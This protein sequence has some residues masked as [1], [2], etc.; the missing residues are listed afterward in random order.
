[1]FPI[2]PTAQAVVDASKDLQ[3]LDAIDQMLTSMSVPHNRS[4]GGLNTADIPQTLF[5][6]I[7]AKKADDVFF[8]RSGQNG[9]FF[10]VTGEESRPL[11][12]EAAFNV[13]RQFIRAEK[14]K[15][16]LGFS[17]VAANRKQ[18][19]RANMPRSWRTKRMEFTVIFPTNTCRESGVSERPS[20]SNTPLSM[21]EPAECQM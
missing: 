21:V 15:A 4:M 13:A 3:T 6:T 19:T 14:I 9:V 16:E 1:M 10:Q 17:S 12:G 2:G 11:E 5:N 20:R 18:S 8:V 7:Q